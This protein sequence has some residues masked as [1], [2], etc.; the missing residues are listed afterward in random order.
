MLR[1]T[2]LLCSNVPA[3]AVTGGAGILAAP[4]HVRAGV[5]ELDS[6]TLVCADTVANVGDEH[7]GGAT[8]ISLGDAPL[9]VGDDFDSRAVHVHLAVALPVE[10]GPRKQSLARR[11]V[12]GQGEVPVRVAGDGTVTD[13]GVED[14][15]SV[16][17][18]EG[19]GYLAAAAIVRSAT[20]DGHSVAAAGT[21]GGGRAASF[22]IQVLG[23]VALAWEVAAAGIEG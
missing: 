4:R 7:V 3:R 12:A 20:G 1:L 10:P 13:V 8:E 16:P 23:I 17:T 19:H 5:R 22:G 11:G 14:L 18:V 9:L 2:A 21:P 15:K 6:S